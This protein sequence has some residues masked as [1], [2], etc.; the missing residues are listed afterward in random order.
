MHPFT[1]VVCGALEATGAGAEDLGG[2][3]EDEAERRAAADDRKGANGQM[4]D[5]HCLLVENDHMQFQSLTPEEERVIAHKGTEM[6]FSGEYD[7]FWEKGTFLCK[8][9]GAELYRSKDKFDAGCGWPSFDEEIP[10]AVKHLPDADGFRTEIQCN[11]C[12]GHLG[13]VFKGEKLTEKDARH[14][15]NSLSLRFVPEKE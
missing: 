7:N 8:R 2:V 1:S 6:P 14:C 3:I 9:C 5:D 10:G 11:D 12:G 15:V 4:F 13:H